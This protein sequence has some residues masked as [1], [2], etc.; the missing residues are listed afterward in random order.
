MLQRLDNFVF[1]LIQDCCFDLAGIAKFFSIFSVAAIIL[2]FSIL[3]FKKAIRKNLIFVLIFVLFLRFL[4]LI[5]NFFFPRARP[6]GSAMDSFFSLHALYAFSFATLIFYRN[7]F[8]GLLAY[9]FAI[10]IGLTRLIFNK[11][12]FTDVFAGALSGVL[13]AILT[14]FFIK[15]IK[16]DLK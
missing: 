14:N 11:H 2:I 5:I 10:V 9:F 1:N 15:K 6:D 8:L 13:I 7:K 12:W 4:D 3:Y 16:W